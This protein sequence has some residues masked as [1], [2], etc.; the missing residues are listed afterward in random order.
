M[1]GVD[2]DN[3]VVCYD[4]VFFSAALAMG[5][6]PPGVE[7]SKPA[8]RE[9]IRS[10]HS[11]EQWMLVQAEVYGPRMAEARAYPGVV[12]FFQ[13]CRALSQPVRVISHKTRFPATGKSGDLREAALRWLSDHGFFAPERV[14]LSP[15]QIV[16]TGTRGE[17][18]CAIAD[19]GCTHF[20]DDLPEVFAEADFPTGV[21]KIL[22]DPAGAFSG[23]TEGIR[24]RSWA[25]IRELIFGDG[26]GNGRRS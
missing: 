25:E 15:E 4:E 16:F 7:R 5:F 8:I 3:T 13:T 20:I 11:D 12:E 19:A 23:W 26:A 9:H 1:I 17:K 18:L 14:L 10:R 21:C 6:I 2:F 24:T 22:F